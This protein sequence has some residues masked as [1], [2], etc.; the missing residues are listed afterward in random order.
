MQWAA[1]AMLMYLRYAL[2]SLDVGMKATL[3]A[4]FSQPRRVEHVVC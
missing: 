2:S 3:L 1:V 4:I